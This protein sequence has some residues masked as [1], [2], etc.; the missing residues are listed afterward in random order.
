MVF[1]AAAWTDVDGCARDQHLAMRRNG[2]A[3][4]ELA[5]ACAAAGSALLFVST[6][7]VFPGDR[8]D[9]HGYRE[10]D[11]TAPL[12][13]Y[14]ASKLAG[15]LAVRDALGE[16]GPGAWIVRTSWVFGP[17]GNDFPVRIVAANDS[18]G[19]K[20][21]LRV[22]DDEIG[23]PTFAPDLAAALV[24]LASV[25]PPGTYHLANAGAA[26]RYEWARAVLSRCRPEAQVEPMALA[27][28]IRASAP[29]PWA[30]LDTGRAE[31]FGVSLRPWR[32][33]LADYLDIVC[34][35]R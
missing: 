33:P 15:E 35:E 28:F 32:E 3:T 5:D 21:P 6:N 2:E 24:R 25:A 16:A 9:G 27:E 10:D 30:V 14:G 26:S 1:H 4:S 13:P 18:S 34:P 22:V 17:P 29:P 11:A 23:R 31:T 19:G 8:T 7:E 20:A 12:N